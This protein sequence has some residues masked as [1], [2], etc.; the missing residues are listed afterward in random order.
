MQLT[1]PQ[2]QIAN[3]TNRFR[4]VV[5][6]R[7]FGKTFLSIREMCYF[8]RIPN[9][10][11]YYIAPT[12]RM[13]KS[14]VW[15][16]LKDR[17]T[18]LRWVKKINETEL[19]IRLINGSKIVLAGADSPERLRGIYVDGI[20]IFDEAASIDP[21]IWT[22]MR[23]ALADKG[24]H[25]MWISSPAGKNHLY[26][27]YSWAQSQDNWSTYKFTTLDGGNVPLE[28]IEAAR[29]EM[30]EREFKQEFLADWVDYV[31]LVYYAFNETHIQKYKEEVPTKL[32]IGNDFNISPICAV[33]AVQTKTGLHIIDEIEIM[34]SNTFELADEIRKRYPNHQINIFPDP[35]GSARKT[36]S[37][38]TD[39]KILYNAG[40]NVHSRRAHPPVKDRINA[41]NGAFSSGKIMIDPSCKSLRNCLN[42][43]SY[44]EGSNEQDKNSGLD[45]MPDALG[46][47]VEYL[48]PLQKIQTPRVEPAR[49]AM[50]APAVRR[51]G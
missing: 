48:Y 47:M 33:V 3:D 16:E 45:H 31:G 42:K 6:G 14:I 27:L 12:Y 36:S 32:F 5:A 20:V 46:Y 34:N 26:E 43:L 41:V 22:V 40:F 37:N 13:C 11:I 39:H 29:Q 8:A 19:T 30:G 35:S 18:Q 24:G 23:P 28:E 17:L 49:W 50:N 21:D 1:K 9:K 7:R 25:A 44:R 38:T 2:Q 10:T 4:I 51:F 15:D